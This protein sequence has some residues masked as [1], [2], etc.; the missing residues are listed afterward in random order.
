[1]PDA[2]LVSSVYVTSVAPSP[3]RGFAGEV[4]TAFERALVNDGK[5]ADA[6]LALPGMSGRKYRRFIN[7]LIELVASPR[8][9]EIGVWQGSTLCSAIFENDVTATAIDNWSEFEGPAGAFL[10]NLS[11]FKGKAKV[12]FLERDFRGVDFHH[13][14]KFNVYL[15]D[16]PHSQKDQYD[17]VM[18]A[19]PALDDVFVLIIDDW[20]W[21]QVREGTL[22]GIRDSRYHVDYLVE[23]RT[24]FDNSHAL[25]HGSESDW[26]NGY[27]IAALR[28]PL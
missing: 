22:D 24:T 16:G 17:G 18:L 25:V 6:V 8:Y 5:I 15:F 11:K 7:N 26:H 20:N 1:M 19:E 14:G 3:M 28:K 9:L 4:R 27:F 21:G 12:S 2:G 10:E 23:V 13:L